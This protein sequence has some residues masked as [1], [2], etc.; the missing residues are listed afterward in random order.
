MTDLPASP[1][2][3]YPPYPPPPLSP[4]AV[5][6]P[7]KWLGPKGGWWI[8]L[9]MTAF[10]LFNVLYDQFVDHNVGLSPN[11][12]VLGGFG[13]TAALT[14]TLAYRLKPSDGISVVR[15]ILAFLLG[16]LLATEL[17]VIIEAPLFDVV[18]RSSP[19]AELISRSL[20]GVIE[21]ACKILAVIIAARGLTTRTARSGLFLGGAVGLGFAAFEDMKYAAA[22][23]PDTL[24][25]HSPLL[26]IITT[27][28]GRDLIGPLEHPVMTALLASV[29]FAATRNG[30]F[31]ITRRVVIA[32]LAIA[33]VHGLI[34]ALPTL[35]VPVVGNQNV[36]NG[37]GAALDILIALGSGV[38]WLVYS[39]RL[40]R[41]GLRA[42]SA[43]VLPSAEPPRA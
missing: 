30:R 18:L 32:Y 31:R 7:R 39:R 6:P 25:G 11:S 4:V 17:A 37:L 26:A 2:P 19:N 3:T 12:L 43:P 15:L 13:M 38:V 22:A 20:A 36:A 33:A 1:P 10:W 8:F 27:T 16:G 9:G 40:N 41:E 34:D 42:R 24:V 28:F 29:L 14:Y 23:I 35:L 5:R 21:E